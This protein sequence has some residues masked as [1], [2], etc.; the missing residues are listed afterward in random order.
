VL[1]DDFARLRRDHPQVDAVI[2]AIL[3]E[4]VRRLSEQVTEAYYLP[5]EARVLRRLRDLAE[6]YGGAVP[7][8]QE[9]L[10]EL[11]GTSRATVNRVLRD[12]QARGVVRLSRANIV[13]LEPER[14]G[15]R[16]SI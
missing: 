11:A 14:L 4:R 3:A 13:V 9:A 12:Q 5:A 10:A 15:P 8:P 7:L 6:L 2:A 1:R 16:V